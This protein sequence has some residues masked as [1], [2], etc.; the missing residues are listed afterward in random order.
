[1]SLGS[2]T[3]LNLCAEAEWLEA[4]EI[5]RKIEPVIA[6]M[7]CG[8][9]PVRTGSPGSGSCF[10]PTHLRMKMP[11]VFSGQFETL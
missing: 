5:S 6:D 8:H 9:V 7:T 10:V 11:H 4:A 3:W 1:M 2:E